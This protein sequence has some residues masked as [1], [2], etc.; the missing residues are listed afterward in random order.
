MHYSKYRETGNMD[1]LNLLYIYT[2]WIIMIVLNIINQYI[3][4]YST[5]R[6][7]RLDYWQIIDM[8]TLGFVISLYVDINK[9]LNSNP[10]NP[11]EIAFLCRAG[12]LCT[13]NILV[14]M[15][16]SGILLSFK[17][18]G[19]MISL[20]YEM[21]IH[22]SKYLIL[23]SLWIICSA[24]IMTIIFFRYSPMC[25]EFSTTIFYLIGGFISNFDARRFSNFLLFGECIFMMYVVVS[26]ILLINLLIASLTSVYE[27]I[28]GKVD[29]SHRSVLIQYYKRYKWE[30]NY[31]YL[32][33][34][35]TP[36]NILNYIVYPISFCFKG[37]KRLIFNQYVVN[38]YYMFYFSL[39]FS[40]FFA[41]T[42][43]VIPL[44]YI[45]GLVLYLGRQTELKIEGLIK[46][47]NISKW[48]FFGIP[49]LCYIFIRDI[50]Y[51]SST[52][53][54]KINIGENSMGRIRKYLTS[55]DVIVFLEFIHSKNNTSNSDLHVL[56]NEYILFE[57]NIKMQQNSR[58]KENL[59]YL[60]RMKTKDGKMNA[61]LFIYN[62]KM[63]QNYDNSYTGRYMKKNLI[64]IE[65][66][67]NFVIEEAN[68]DLD[69]KKVDIE[70]LKMLLPKTKNV[71]NSYMN[72]LIYT[73]ICSL[74]KALNKL[75][76]KRDYFLQFTNMNK[77]VTKAIKLDKEIDKEVMKFY[78]RKQ[79]ELS[80]KRENVIDENEEYSFVEQFH[81]L[82]FKL[83][84]SVEEN[85]M[86]VKPI[87][88]DMT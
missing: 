77:I 45:K 28:M 84:N 61:N 36:L 69:V 47:L 52:V 74:N 24:A 5:K 75:K 25:S 7:F 72:R 64:I 86:D 49:F 65:T 8:I 10:D 76:Y 27:E 32:I 87:D 44:C 35:T 18:V 13:N 66:L 16:I 14:W 19:P 80:K 81:N 43:V 48:I 3:F 85:A 63:Y 6:K 20:I 60:R 58:M 50:Y 73:D 59:K 56:F 31:G 55:D 53:Y 78:R 22:L 41:I 15:R 12:L 39:I 46:F 37:P 67:E 34:L 38:F 11:N 88:Y 71:D 2:F 17:E 82:L 70:K 42:L 68:K 29:A 26:G 9:F 83:K 51:I 40:F 30:P 23:Y 54:K 62:T 21:L 33:F 1:M 79:V 4:V 57:Q